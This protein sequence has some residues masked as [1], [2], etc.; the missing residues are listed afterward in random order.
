MGEQTVGSSIIGRPASSPA[1]AV[2]DSDVV[3]GLDKPVTDEI[4]PKE[5]TLS[6]A[7]PTSPRDWTV[8]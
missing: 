8:T 7:L 4:V 6:S 3:C 5:R 2:T 1:S